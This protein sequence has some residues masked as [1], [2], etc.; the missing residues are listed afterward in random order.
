VVVVGI[1][2]GESD[3]PMTAARGFVEQHRLTYPVLV[4]ADDSIAEAFGVQ[5]FPTNAILDREGKVVYMESG[6]N[7]AAI[8]AKLEELMKA[9]QAA[10]GR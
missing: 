2:T 10:A 1:N 8:D 9:S 4:D 3:D 6:F 7:R 5:A